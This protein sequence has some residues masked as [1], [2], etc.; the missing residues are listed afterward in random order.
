MKYCQ[1]NK[2]MNTQQIMSVLFRVS[3][4]INGI[5]SCALAIAFPYYLLQKGMPYSDFYLLETILFLS[6]G[7]GTLFWGN[8]LDKTNNVWDL[9]LWILAFEVIFSIAFLLASVFL[10]SSVLV[11]ATL[12]GI[13]EFL[14]AFEIP[15]SRIAY[16][17]LREGAGTKTIAH[18]ITIAAAFISILAPAI[19]AFVGNYGVLVWIAIFNIISLFPY[20]IVTLLC[21]KKYIEK[22]NINSMIESVGYLH[23]FKD[24]FKQSE[25]IILTIGI[26]LTYFSLGFLMAVLPIEIVNDIGT[27]S[28]YL[29]P[30]FYFTTGLIVVVL[31]STKVRDSIPTRVT[32]SL[33]MITILVTISGIGFFVSDNWLLKTIFY[34]IYSTFWVSLSI[35]ITRRIYE[36][37]VSQYQGKLFAYI[38][39]VSRFSLPLASLILALLPENIIS[40]A[41][42]VAFLFV[43]SMAVVLFSVKRKNLFIRIETEKV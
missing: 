27:E 17:R 9:K 24:L 30:L 22:H 3:M 13:L 12:I 21:S 35:L 18:E 11:L 41:P 2:I 37:D 32:S 31:N 15:W 28:D 14:F 36:D 1:Y 29:I 10:S 8:R 40:K 26:A 39:L 6:A 20:A 42:F 4:V 23:M 38:N 25:W 16:N 34:T 7:I 33:Q 43:S 5:G 19:G